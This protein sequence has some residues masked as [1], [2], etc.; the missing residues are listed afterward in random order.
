MPSESISHAIG[1]MSLVVVMILVG[2]A[3]AA[4]GSNSSRE[5]IESQLGDVAEYVASETVSILSILNMTQNTTLIKE[6][7]IPAS[8]G[9]QGYTIRFE[10][11]SGYWVTTARLDA[12][13]TSQRRATLPW[14][15]LGEGSIAVVTNGSIPGGQIK[16]FLYSGASHP[17]VWCRRSGSGGVEVGLGVID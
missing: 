8:V 16:E 10:T 6:L 4:I 13:P 2:A 3:F 5:A 7:S 12:A 15:S 14:K 17:A 1:S 9:G 11:E